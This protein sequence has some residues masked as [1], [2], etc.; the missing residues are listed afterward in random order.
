MSDLVDFFR[1]EVRTFDARLAAGV[2]S[3]GTLSEELSGFESNDVDQI[4]DD[5]NNISEPC[6]A[7]TIADVF[8]HFVSIKMSH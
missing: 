7:P 2:Y 4:I 5:I 6:G 1:R 8:D 3:D